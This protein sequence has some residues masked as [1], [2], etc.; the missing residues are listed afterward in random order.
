MKVTINSDGDYM[1]TGISGDDVVL[2]KSGLTALHAS[3]KEDLKYVI[4]EGYK[5]SLEETVVDTER[6]LEELNNPRFKAEVSE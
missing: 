2:I 1:I 4:E 5:K 6:I 3:S